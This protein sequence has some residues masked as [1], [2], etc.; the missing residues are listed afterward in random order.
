MQISLS[1]L[2]TH[3]ELTENPEEIADLLTNCGLEVEDWFQFESVKGG[4]KGLVV[5][6]ITDLAQHPNADKL[7]LAKVNIG[8]DNL[9]NIVCGAPNVQLGQKVIVAPI[10]VTIFPTTGEPMTMKKAKIRGE[11]SEG[12]LCAEDEIG[13]GTGHEGLYILSNHSEVGSPVSEILGS[14]SD[15]IFEIGLTP[16]RGDAASHLGVA[17]DLKA[18]LNRQLLKLPSLEIDPKPSP[19][20]QQV[21]IAEPDSCLRYCGLQIDNINLKPS[22]IWLQNRLKSIGLTPINHVVDV[23]NFIMHD[24]GQ[25]LHA[26]DANKVS[27][28]IKVRKAKAGEKLITLDQIERKLQG[29]ELIIADNSGPIALAGVM[30]GISTS[31][32]PQT[33]SVFLESAAFNAVHVRKTAKLHGINT[34]SSFR[35]ER[36]IDPLACDL[37]VKYAAKLILEIG[38]GEIGGGLIEVKQGFPESLKTDFTFDKFFK[39]TGV[40][41]ETDE[42]KEILKNLDIQ[43]LE[44]KADALRL[45]LPLYRS[46][47]TR[48]IDV[49]EE[50]LRIYGFNKVPLPKVLHSAPVGRL[51]PDRDLIRQ[52][53]SDYLADQ[54]FNEI[55]T[56]SLTRESYFNEETNQKTIKLLNPL[57]NELAILRPEILPSLLESVAYNKNRKSHDLKF[58]EFGKVYQQGETG[59]KEFEKLAIVV[60]G[61]KTGPNWQQKQQK[62]NYYFLK[63][64]MNNCLLKVG[65]G[66]AKGVK[67]ESVPKSLLQNL[68]IKSEVWYA[69][70]TVDAILSAHSKNKFKLNEIPLFPEVTRDLS[71]VLAKDVNYSDIETVTSQTVGKY[72]R[73]LT[74]FDVFEGKPLPENQKAYAISLILYDSEKTMN[75]KQ[76]DAIMQKLIAT[77]ENQLKAIIRK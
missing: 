58:F 70:L 29:D 2:K 68:G 3:I 56:N 10:G 36:G 63:S 11:E 21:E 53:I 45:K 30:G 59:F 55:M 57:S 66:R 35:F 49:Y 8:K 71:L 73:K 20:A 52:T 17:R 16:N 47:V 75:D 69:E 19:T 6:Q 22:P 44:E 67:I 54:G 38:G 31:I 76:I 41:I 23:T 27:G 64:V 33:V 7:K 13:L 26:F 37:A 48:E 18:L 32:G 4:F 5:G 60:T 62:V 50:V 9:L 14:E 15:I 25:P 43:I 24:R 12:M 77:F 61:S 72:L 39:F 74:V 51:K 34:D 46:D 65:A 42:I 40:E 1:W 28:T